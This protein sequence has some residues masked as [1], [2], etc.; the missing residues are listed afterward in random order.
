MRLGQVAQALQYYE[1]SLAQDQSLSRNHLSLAAAYL[2]QGNQ[3]KAAPHLAQYVNAFPEHYV[4]R[5]HYAELLLRLGRPE[6]AR[7]HFERFVADIQDQPELAAKHLIHCHSR[8]MEIAETAG[9]EYNEHLHRGI[10]LYL[11]ACERAKL[12]DVDDGQLNVES[13]LCKAA[14]E[15]TMARLQRRQEARPCWYLYEVWSRLSQRQPSLA[16]LE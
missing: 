5:A 1:L 16:A 11:L 2:E 9:D 12:T 7:E 13:V 4:V 10:G 3:A 14:G 8:L 6:E 15:L